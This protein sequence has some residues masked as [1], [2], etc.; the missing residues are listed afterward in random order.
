MAGAAS[1]CS[2]HGTRVSTSVSQKSGQYSQ[3]TPEIDNNDTNI[4]LVMSSR[5]LFWD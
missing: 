5:N 4:I 1:T 3:I 2:C